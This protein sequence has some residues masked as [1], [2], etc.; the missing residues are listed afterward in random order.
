M[1]DIGKY[2][3]LYLDNESMTGYVGET[4][5]LKKRHMNHKGSIWPGRRELVSKI[6]EPVTIKTDFKSMTAVQFA[7]HTAYELYKGLGYDMLQ[8]PPHP[9]VFK[10]YK[11]RVDDCKICD[12][13]GC[14]FTKE[15]LEYIL[16]V[17]RVSKLCPACEKIFYFDPLKHQQIETFN[18]IECCSHSCAAKKRYNDP[19]ERLKI[20]ESKKGKKHT[21]ETKK[22]QSVANKGEN[23]PA[24]KITECDAR[25]IKI[26]LA[27][28]KMT[29]QQIANCL[30]RATKSIIGS[31][32]RGIA[33][34]DIKID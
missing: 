29:H 30:P 22:K 33:W 17:H 18:R 12:E 31:I 13:L 4:K 11:D 16:A 25:Q 24:S 26:L 34:K 10:K 20:S 14:D 27:T 2:L 3:Y 28:T 7:E 1:V 19:N 23:N 15:R 8:K 6:G 5:N 9:N 32:S 21:V